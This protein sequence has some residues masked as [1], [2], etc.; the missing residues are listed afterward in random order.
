[1]SKM[2][3]EWYVETP[4]RQF[5]P[6]RQKVDPEMTIK[7]TYPQQNGRDIHI[8]HVLSLQTIMSVNNIDLIVLNKRGEALKEEAVAD[9]TKEVF[10]QNHF[11]SKIK[12]SGN[13]NVKKER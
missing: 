5:T 3:N 8:L 4:P 9:L 2:D 12:F 10:Y 11:N 7:L 6:R 13:I 1:M